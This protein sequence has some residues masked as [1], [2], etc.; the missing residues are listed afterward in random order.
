MNG[1][2][3]GGHLV[4]NGIRVT[5]VIRMRLW[6]MLGGGGLLLAVVPLAQLG[7]LAVQ[8]QKTKPEALSV[9]TVVVAWCLVVCC[10]SQV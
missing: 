4:I 5:I 9:C 7:A 1:K 6:A 2:M 8:H 3:A 10:L